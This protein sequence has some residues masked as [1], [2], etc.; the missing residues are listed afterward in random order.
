MNPKRKYRIFYNNESIIIETKQSIKQV[1]R[2]KKQP[3]YGKYCSKEQWILN[4]KFHIELLEK[5]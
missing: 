2:Q 5:F 1:I 3:I 4:H